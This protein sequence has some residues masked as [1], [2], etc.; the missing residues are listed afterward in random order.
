MTAVTPESLRSKDGNGNRFYEFPP[1][2]ELFP[3][4]TTITGGTK[5]TPYLAAWGSKVAALYAAGNLRELLALAEAAE[6]WTDG[7]KAVVDLVKK[8]ATRIRDLKRDTGSYVHQVV[9]ALT[10][11]AYSPGRTGKDI[12]LPSLPDDLA[13]G[14]YDDEPVEDVADFMVTGFLNFVTDF[15]PVFLATEMAVFNPDLRVAGTLDTIFALDGRDLSPRGEL[16]ARPGHRLT[17]CGDVK[18]GKNLDNTVKEQIT[19]Y[20]RMKL[21]LLQLG[22]LIPMPPTDIAA[23]LHLRPEYERGYRFMPVSRRD[24]ALAWN[25]F[26]RALELWTG[27][28]EAGDK[29]GIPAYPLRP[30]GTVPPRLLRDMDGEGYGRAPGALAKAGI[31]DVEFLAAMTAEECKELKGIGDATVDAARRLLA[32]EGLC[33]ADETLA[34]GEAA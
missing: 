20:R 4:V 3:G 34:T 2:H 22:E 9:E 14:L 33:F 32:A 5:G 12:T 29:P 6:T 1:T 13:G 25:R 24:D 10:L 27:R 26:R 18:S 8:E 7:E 23:V 19:A 15:E 28:E 11:W 17:I 31:D 30:D 21:A 16:V